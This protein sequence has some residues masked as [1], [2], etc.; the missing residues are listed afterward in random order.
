[1]L[2]DIRIYDEGYQYP[3]D[4]TY[5]V[6]S[7]TAAQKIKAGE[8]VYKALGQRYATAMVTLGPTTAAMANTIF[9]IASSTSTDTVAA[10]G[11]VNVMPI[12]GTVT[13][14]IKPAA[15]DMPTY[16][17]TPATG[18]SVQATYNA[19]VGSRVRLVLTGTAVAGTAT[20]TIETPGDGADNGCVIEPLDIIKYP[21]WVRFSVR[22]P[23]TT[24]GWA[25][26]IS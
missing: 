21:G 19:L 17:Y 5:Q 6:A 14:L 25:T 15:A 7:A 20:Y 3:G 11:T 1:M 22:V 16:G 24:N 9:G 23:A 8:P 4:E 18:V 10:A 12:D 13:F 26:G 2:G